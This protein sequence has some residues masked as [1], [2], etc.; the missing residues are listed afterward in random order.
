MVP[1]SRWTGSS[2]ARCRS[3]YMLIGLCFGLLG[4]AE[5]RAG[6]PD[7]ASSA[8]AG[9]EVRSHPEADELVLLKSGAWRISEDGV[10][11]ETDRRVVLVRRGTGDAVLPIDFEETPWH[12]LIGLR[13]WVRFP[14]GSVESYTD[15]VSTQETGALYTDQWFRRLRMPELPSESLVALEVRSRSG[16]S[17][18]STGSWSPACLAPVEHAVFQLHL[19]PPWTCES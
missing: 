1:E 10:R 2:A 18:S 8:L 6:L 17:Q 4:V 13:A 14:D 7:W 9:S 15:I 3:P 16:L 12:A 11:E 5:T 19:P